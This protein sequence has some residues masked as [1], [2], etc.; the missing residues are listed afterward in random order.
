[1]AG[2][3]AARPCERLILEGTGV[4]LRS[5]S[6]RVDQDSVHLK[7]QLV[8]TRPIVVLSNR[9]A[10]GL[11]VHALEAVLQVPMVEYLQHPSCFAHLVLVHRDVRL[12][13]HV[14]DRGQSNLQRAQSGRQL[15]G[16]FH[17]CANALRVIDPSL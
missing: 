13:C 10:P 12:G 8:A 6:M 15:Q 5:E 1:M 7:Q 4:Q 17:S 3:V 9:A 16:Q 11:Y 14:L 2:R